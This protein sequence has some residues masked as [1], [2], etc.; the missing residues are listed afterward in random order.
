VFDGKYRLL[1]LIGAGSAGSVYEAENMVV[2]KKVAIKILHSDLAQNDTLRARFAAEARAGAQ[3][4]HPNIVDIYDFGITSEGTPYIVMELLHGE[5][6]E[7]LLARRGGLAPALACELMVQILAGL[8]AAHRMGIVHRDL[9]PANIVITHPRPDAPLVKMLDFGIAKGVLELTGYE[10]IMG[11]PLYMSPEQARASD[12]GPQADIY[13]AGVMLYEMLAG[14]PPFTG[15]TGEVLR[16]VIAGQWTP[17]SNANPAVP[18]R[19]AL[20]VT[21][22]MATDPGRRLASARMFAKQLAPYVSAAPPHSVPTGPNSAD[23][24]LLRAASPVPEIRMMSTSDLPDPSRPPR[25]FPSLQLANVAGRPK[26]EPLAD[27]LLQSPII[28]RAPTAPKIHV[29]SAIRDVELWSNAPGA[30]GERDEAAEPEHAVAPADPVSRAPARDPVLD[31]LAA[32]GERG[33]PSKEGYWQRGMW[34]AA[35]GVSIGAVLAW[36]YRFG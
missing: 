1:R 25:D 6:L 17:L 13:A 28:P 5:T 24:F 22:A 19:L 23:A 18:R 35:L 14:E 30:P 21:A 26:G 32:P 12:V 16:K 10:G 11:T 8:G 4:G 15:D 3:I 20:T 34:A 29:S 27:S 31:S 33:S 36:L 7:E 2:G 9:K